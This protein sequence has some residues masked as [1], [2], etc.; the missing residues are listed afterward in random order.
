MNTDES[1]IECATP[2]AAGTTVDH[3]QIKFS[4]MPSQKVVKAVHMGDYANLKTTYDEISIWVIM[5]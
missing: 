2:V 5:G 3:D 1:T 4:E